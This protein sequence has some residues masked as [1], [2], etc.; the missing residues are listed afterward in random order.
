MS[1]K[2]PRKAESR[3]A[4]PK[5]KPKILENRQGVFRLFRVNQGK[6]PRPLGFFGGVIGG[7]SCRKT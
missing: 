3:G 5:L 7:A 2:E 4:D 1:K 6:I